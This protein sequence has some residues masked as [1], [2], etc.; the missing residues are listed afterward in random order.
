MVNDTQQ[1]KNIAYNLHHELPIDLRLRILENQVQIGDIKNWVLCRDEIF[2]IA[3]K[4]FARAV[5]KVFRS[6]S[7]LLDFFTLFQIFCLRL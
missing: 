6:C 4:N 1:N 5:T 7:I 2:I 3:V